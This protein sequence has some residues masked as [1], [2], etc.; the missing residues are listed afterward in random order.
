[1]NKKNIRRRKTS[2]PKTRTLDKKFEENEKKT[3]VDPGFPMG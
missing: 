2:Y 3:V 1:M